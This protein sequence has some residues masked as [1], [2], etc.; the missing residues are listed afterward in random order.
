MIAPKII[1]L[2]LLLWTP[3]LALHGE[4]YTQSGNLHSITKT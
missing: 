2:T 4:V 3:V 1:S